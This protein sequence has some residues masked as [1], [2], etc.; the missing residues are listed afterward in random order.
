MNQSLDA[1]PFRV[2]LESETGE[3]EIDLTKVSA[4]E[5]LRNDMVRHRITGTIPSGAGL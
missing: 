5:V 3:K 2:F 4:A 1:K